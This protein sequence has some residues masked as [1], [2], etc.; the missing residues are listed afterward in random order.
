MKTLAIVAAILCVAL[1]SMGQEKKYSY[2][3]VL[4]EYKLGNGGKLV[5]YVD[6]GDKKG[7][8]GKRGNN[9]TSH[10]Q[11]TDETGKPME[12]LSEV[13]AVNYMA[14]KGWELVQVYVVEVGGTYVHYMMKKPVENSN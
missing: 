12:F 2:C 3:D 6:F 1:P 13:E 14:A 8:P 7:M 9:H 4:P 11:I 5:V 10:T